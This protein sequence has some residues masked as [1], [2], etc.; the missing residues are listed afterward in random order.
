MLCTDEGG[1][2]TSGP[3]LGKEYLATK[4]QANIDP[5]MEGRVATYL[6]NWYS[7]GAAMGPLNYFVAGALPQ[8]NPL[9]YL[10]S[11]H[12]CRDSHSN[13]SVLTPL[14]S[15][16][17]Q[18]PPTSSISALFFH[19]A[20]TNMRAKRASDLLLSP[21]QIRLLW[22]PAG[23]ALAGLIQ[24]KR[25]RRSAAEAT[26]RHTQG[27]HRSWNPGGTFCR[28]LLGGSGRRTQ[29][30]AAAISLRLLWCQ[31][32]VRLLSPDRRQGP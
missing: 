3:N 21:P 12:A 16:C 27:T 28:E 9:P 1:P 30:G 20:L 29:A 7:W 26:A 32:H 24:G 14:G 13:S 10:G 25:T 18:A 2:D 4:G 31:H 6:T 17:L 5:R 15:G 19:I 8:T 11:A 22:H 23:H